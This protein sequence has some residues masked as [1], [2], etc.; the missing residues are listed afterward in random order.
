MLESQVNRPQVLFITP[1]CPGAESHSGGL[2][3]S[4]ERIRSITRHADVTIVSIGEA[5]DLAPTRNIP[6]VKGIHTAGKVEPRN[7]K[8]YLQ[9][10]TSGLPIS[11]WRNKSEAFL[12]LCERLQDEEWDYIYADHWLIWPAVR[13]AGSAKK[14]L[15]LHNAE[16]MLFA[17]AAETQRMPVK[18]ALILEARKVA[19]YLR[20]ICQQADEVHYLSEADQDEI[21]KVGYRQNGLVFPPSVQVEERR[22]GRYGGNLLFAGTL[23]WQ[24]NEE[25]LGWFIKAVAPMLRSTLTLDILGGQPSSGLR[26]LEGEDGCRLVW[27]GRVPSVMPFYEAASVFVAP[28]LSGS[29][30][31]IKI[32]NAL[33]HGLPVVTTSVGIEGFPRDWK[34]CI[35]VADSPEEFA[36]AV[37]HLFHDRT[38]WE[39]ASLEGQSYISRHFSGVQF[40]QWC[41]DLRKRNAL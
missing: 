2:Q 10:L 20:R 24:P 8:S 23:S 19:A 18:L 25:G 41:S 22:Y 32:L 40:A 30:I 16:H 27:Q 9:S 21:K 33:S 38:A 29:G 31:K 36:Q 13:I 28:L 5:G 26:A 4:L 1:V 39:R 37:Q 7:L 11:V 35:H 6:G 12:A 34:D 14:I 17:R 3:V 15:H